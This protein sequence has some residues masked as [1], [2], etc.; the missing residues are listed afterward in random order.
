MG[1]DGSTHVADNELTLRAY[2]L[3]LS[4]FAFFLASRSQGFVAHPAGSSGNLCL[5]GAIGR[6]VGP[7]QIFDVGLGRVA[8]LRV[9]LTQVPT[10]T[11]LVAVQ[12]GETWN[13]QCWHRDI[14]GTSNFS[15]G[16]SIAFD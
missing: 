13:F 8:S 10:P 11:G 16:L 6:F 7:G 5:A 12:P 2:Q 9:D 4:T 14:G 3:P 1:A 15:D